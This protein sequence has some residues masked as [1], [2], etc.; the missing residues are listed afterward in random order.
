MQALGADSERCLLSE[1]ARSS[2]AGPFDARL[3]RQH[4][5]AGFAGEFSFYGLR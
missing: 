1:A 4:P 3:L 5:L 2:L